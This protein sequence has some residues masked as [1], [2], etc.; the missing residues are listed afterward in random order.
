MS[1]TGVSGGFS[2]ASRRQGVVG[3]FN[4]FQRDF[5][6]FVD[7]QVSGDIMGFQKRLKLFQGVLGRFKLFD[8]VSEG[9][10]R[11]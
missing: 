6:S 11:A 3:R 7:S 5:S 2:R 10:R 1:L 4:K 9:I 8:K